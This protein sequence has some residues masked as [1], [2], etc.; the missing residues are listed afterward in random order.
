MKTGDFNSFYYN[1]KYRNYLFG[2]NI[3]QQNELVTRLNDH[4]K[5]LYTNSYNIRPKTKN[6]II[7]D[8]TIHLYKVQAVPLQ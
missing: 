3:I 2:D 5:Y 4:V 7:R 6:Q 8:R 1:V